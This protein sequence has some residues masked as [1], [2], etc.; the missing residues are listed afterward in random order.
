M[1][2]ILNITQ[3]NDHVLTVRLSRWGG[4]VSVSESAGV[5]VHAVAPW[6][7]KIELER[8]VSTQ[9]EGFIEAEWPAGLRPGLYGLEVS[10]TLS[11]E[12]RW[13]AR[14]ASVV[15]VTHATDQDAEEVT[16][17]A[18]SY[19]VTLVIGIRRGAVGVTEE[20]RRKIAGIIDEEMV[21]GM[22]GDRGEKGD[23]GDPGEKGEKGDPGE[24]GET[25][26][27]GE[28][29]DK[30]EPGEKG[31]PG[32]DGLDGGILF[33]RMDF[34]PENGVLTVSGEQREVDRI[35]YD[36]ETAQ[37]ILKL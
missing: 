9:E 15:R 2:R 28:K 14:G 12:G 36:E 8:Q 33:P 22:K 16:L 27:K 7:E 35:G 30:G 18:D 32:R 26:E 6:G 24:K 1:K 3:N 21:A 17:Q 13:T 19:D 25:G 5:T 11:G 34:N 37:L 4:P 10:G 23:K 20:L 31:E 29:G